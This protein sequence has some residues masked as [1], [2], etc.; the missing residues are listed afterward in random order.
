MSL[1]S[2]YSEF[3]TRHPA[4]GRV[5]AVSADRRQVWKAMLAVVAAIAVNVVIFLVALLIARKLEI[6]VTT[7]YRDPTAVGGLPFVTGWASGLGAAAW[8]SGGAVCL[9]SAFV[10]RPVS[11]SLAMLG[12]L[13]LAMGLDDLLMIHEEVIPRLGGMEAHLMVVYAI[14]ASAWFVFLYAPKTLYGLIFVAAFGALGS[15]A[16]IDVVLGPVFDFPETMEGLVEDVGKE[17][18]ITLWL[19]FCLHYAYG[20]ITR[21]S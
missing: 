10:V 17:V 6:G 9:F 8:I 12:L 15:S 11:G 3:T 7:I 5:L 21:R 16:I 2:E 14:L 19:I 20:E 1:F 18:G 13:T 4:I